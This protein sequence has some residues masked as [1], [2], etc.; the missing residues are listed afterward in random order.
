[1]TVGRPLGKDTL[2]RV[3]AGAVKDEYSGQTRLDWTTATQ[4][5]I[6]GCDAQ[7]PLITMED[8]TNR[9]LVLFEWTVFC[10]AGT[11]ITAY[12]RAIFNGNT[13]EVWSNPSQ[14]RSYSGRLDHVQVNLR[15]WNG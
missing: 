14:P 3:R 9:D 5:P 13:Y 10:P 8:P 7:P 1:M 2:I 4:T 15:R 12:D 6:K 11:D